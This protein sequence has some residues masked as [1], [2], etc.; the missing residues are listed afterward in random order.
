MRP[1][2]LRIA[3]LLL[4]AISSCYAFEW[5]EC[6]DQKSSVQ[7][8]VKVLLTPEPVPAGTTANFT[9]IGVSGAVTM[10]LHTDTVS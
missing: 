3:V 2:Q 8:A 9:I 1:A 5:E 4:I 7:K 10:R 6:P